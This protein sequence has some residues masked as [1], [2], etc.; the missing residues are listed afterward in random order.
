MTRPLDGVEAKIRRA[1]EHMYAFRDAYHSVLQADP[2]G[3]GLKEDP[4][5]GGY[6]VE[7]QHLPTMPSDLGVIVGDVLHC[8]RSALDHLVWE[9]GRQ[10]VGGK[11]SSASQFPITRNPREFAGQLY[12]IADLSSEKKA[13]VESA[14]P[15]NRGGDAS[16]LLTL[17]RLS[18]MDK[19]RVLAPMLTD[20]TALALDFEGVN[21]TVEET[22]Y[23][24]SGHRLNVGAE[25]ACL[26]LGGDPVDPHVRMH[27]H[28][29][30]D[31]AFEE[32]GMPVITELLLIGSEVVLVSREFEPLLELFSEPYFLHRD[33]WKTWP[34]FSTWP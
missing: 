24:T 14:Q 26:K 19:H 10:T 27:G 34:T 31:V 11:P 23:L 1:K 7:V 22:T 29:I 28:V 16:P 9:A 6:L 17:N 30:P 12:R 25:I 33:E 4:M 21:C 15:Y 18:N 32:T 2:V 8:F 20:V 3:I 13:V 5:A